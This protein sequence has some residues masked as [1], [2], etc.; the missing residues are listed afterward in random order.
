MC[1]HEM[2]DGD[3]TLMYTKGY[4]FSPFW[5]FLQSGYYRHHCEDS[6]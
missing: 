2:I 1:S 4:N 6:L 5:I 3:D